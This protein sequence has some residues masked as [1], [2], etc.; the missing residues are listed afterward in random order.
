LKKAVGT[1]GH[2]GKKPN[3]FEVKKL[4]PKNLNNQEFKQSP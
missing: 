2:N 1:L 4:K 3:V